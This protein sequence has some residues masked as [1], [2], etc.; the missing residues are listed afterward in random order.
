MLGRGRVRGGGSDPTEP[1]GLGVGEGRFSPKEMEMLFP[2]DERMW[3]RL[4]KTTDGHH[5]HYH[6]EVPGTEPTCCQISDHR[7]PG[8]PELPGPLMLN[9]QLLGGGLRSERD[10]NDAWSI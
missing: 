10:S 8:D 4:V 3:A 6:Q 1:S 7:F 2:E 5:R 9:F